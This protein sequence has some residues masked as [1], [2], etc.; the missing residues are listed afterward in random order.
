[1]SSNPGV[2][3]GAISVLAVFSTLF[4]QNM[5][6]RIVEN[7]FVGM[8]GGYGLVL[9]YNNVMAKAITPLMKGDILFL[10]PVVIGLLLFSRFNKQVSYLGRIPM[11][12]VVSIGAA[13]AMRGAVQAEFVDQI[14]ATVLPLTSID[15]ILL[16]VG[17]ICVA[18]Y[19]VFTMKTVGSGVTSEIGKWIMMV[20][21]GAAFGNAVQ[22]RISLFIAQLQFLMGKWLGM[23]KV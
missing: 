23:I 9:A 3:L 10:V 1:M 2:W 19:F 8:A 12:F 11:A 16:V 18:A 7:T 22:G 17:T 15:N 4:K 5:V 13:L 6:A 20:A 21:F 14:V